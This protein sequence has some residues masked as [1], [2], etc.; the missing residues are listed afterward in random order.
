MGPLWPIG[1]NMKRSFDT[2]AIVI[3]GL[4]LALEI[5]LQTIG[6]YLQFGAANINLS[7]I[8]VV[9]A[10]VLCGPISGGILGFFN[11]IMALLSPSTIAFFMP[12]SP[13]GT[14]LVCLLKCTLAGVIAGFV[15]D[16]F[17]KIGKNHLSTNIVGYFVASAIVPVV[18]TGLFAAGALIFFQ[19]RLVERITEKMP[20]MYSV[21]I[22]GFI[23]INF[24]I[25][26]FTTLLVTPGIA[27]VLYKREE[28][29][30][31]K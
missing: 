31:N 2:K 1:G 13:F 18:N 11:G 19:Q 8:P 21:L 15:F 17:R 24:I 16:V 25:E 20:D 7:L 26:F 10:A 30:S 29:S 14:A 5:V 9:L 4:L 23:G 3:T 6:N 22:F 27:V 12:V 28:K